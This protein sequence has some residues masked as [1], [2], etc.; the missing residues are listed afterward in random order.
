MNEWVTKHERMLFN[1]KLKSRA[2]FLLILEFLF[3]GTRNLNSVLSLLNY[4]GNSF[5]LHYVKDQPNFKKANFNMTKPLTV[6]LNLKKIPGWYPSEVFL[7][8]QSFDRLEKVNLTEVRY[9]ATDKYHTNCLTFRFT[10]TNNGDV[11]T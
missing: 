6:L 9:R 5:Y 7:M 4:A 10:D 11:L 1:I 2:S 3:L 8:S